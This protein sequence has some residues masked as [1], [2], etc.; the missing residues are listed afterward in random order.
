MSLRFKF[1]L[2]FALFLAG[3]LF[4]LHFF[5]LPRFIVFEQEELKHHEQEDIAFFA[6]S[7]LPDILV[8]DL[9]KI[10]ETLDGFLAKREYWQEI[11]MEDSAGRTIYPIDPAGNFGAGSTHIESHSILF[12]EKLIAQVRV[13]MRFDTLLEEKIIKIHML[14]FSL[15]G[16]LAVVALISI[17][18]QELFILSPLKKLA[19]A[20]TKIA[21]GSFNVKLPSVSG[22]EIGHFNMAFDEMR[23]NL[24]TREEELAGSQKRLAAIIE[25]TVDSIVTINTKGEIESANRATVDI[26]GYTQ[27][28]LQ[29][30]NVSMLMPEPD[31]SLHDS[32]LNNYMS[33]GTSKLIGI[34]R[35]VLGRHRDG[36]IFPIDLAV[37]EV[38]I[39]NQI[40]FLGLIRDITERKQAHEELLQAK[41]AAE[42]AGK[43]KSNF[44]ANMSHEIRTPMNAIIGMSH[45]LDQ[46]QLD[47]RQQDYLDKID[48]S[49]HSLL[50]II[51]DILDFSK[52]EAGLLEMEKI[53]FHL[54]TVLENLANLVSLLAEEKELDV[55]FSTE[56][57]LPEVLVGDPLRLGQILLNLVNNAIKF[58]E[59]GEIVLRVTQSGKSQP[60]ESC[61]LQFIVE[62]TGIGMSPEQ[63]ETLFKPFTQ[64]DVSITRRYGGT[65]LGLAISKQLIQLIGGEISVESTP[66]KG[67]IFSFTAYFG[68]KQY[69]KDDMD[70][71]WKD[72]Q[73]TSILVANTTPT[74]REILRTDLEFFS[75]QVT[76]ASSGEDALAQITRAENDNSPFGAIFIDMRMGD[77]NGL[78]T[79]RK[80]KNIA[81]SPK[82]PVIM[83]ASNFEKNKFW[84]QAR[85]AG[86]DNLITKPFHRGLL[87]ETLM[88]VFNGMPSS[89][90]HKRK[91]RHRELPEL[92]SISGAR[93]LL[94]EDNPINQLVAK[95]ILENA[96]LVVEVAEN[97]V[98]AVERVTGDG[99]AI[100]LVLMDIHMPE[101]DGHKA[102]RLIRS[103]EK[104]TDLPIIALT[105][106]VMSDDQ[107]K[108]MSSGMNACLAKPID[109]AKL[110]NTLLQWIPPRQQN[111]TRPPT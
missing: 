46:T 21:A 54:D 56:P 4:F 6:L 62:D 53:D 109:V 71:W 92:D 18:F 65:G 85:A 36:S 94:V 108:Y 79:A 89:E 1:L 16:I 63:A 72:F 32:Y 61:C 55:F 23:K 60:E 50:N 107:E 67:S 97:G 17:F 22:D 83:M 82:S 66:G 11:V 40:I 70:V 44:L 100:E 38:H 103:H 51:N 52:I 90:D 68:H 95:K 111:E 39:D 78:E 43:A 110:H 9:A 10:H 49:S 41:E 8:G 91:Y 33:T 7:M 37:N 93:V 29:G 88:R 96:G 64:V 3:S 69:E 47:S 13:A 45:L 101:M 104:F 20:S 28:E 98:L 57:G 75:F 14:E 27:E 105:A 24:Q 74:G 80:I 58:T 76:E 77:M 12:Q 19:E 86:V 2:P 5:W 106:N 48:S 84:D 34:G 81:S 73:D 25:N 102:S 35:E 31:H 15:V 42:V 87:K 26:F 30:Q 59:Q 99:E